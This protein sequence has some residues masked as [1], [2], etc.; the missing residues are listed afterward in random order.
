MF[1]ILEF[2]CDGLIAYVTELLCYTCIA[3]AR[4]STD[5]AWFDSAGI[6]ESDCSD[7][8]FQSVPDGMISSGFVNKWCFSFILHF[9]SLYIHPLNLCFQMC[10]L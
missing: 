1:F 6:L 9:V 8:D 3:S 7:E 5:E 4:A 2:K 10:Y